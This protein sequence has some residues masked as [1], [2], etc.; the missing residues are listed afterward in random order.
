MLKILKKWRGYSGILYS[1]LFLV[2]LWAAAEAQ[3]I[4]DSGALIKQ[5]EQLQEKIVPK[6]DSLPEKFDY[7]PLREGEGQT[8]LIREIRFSGALE[9]VPES[10]LHN[11]VADAIGKNLDFSGLQMLVN[12]VTDYLKKQG[13]FLAR[14]Y[15]PEQDVTEGVLEIGIL[16]GHLSSD[17]P[18]DI[19]FPD[20]NPRISKKVLSNVV[21]TAL[22]SGEAVNENRINR[23]V[24]LINDFPGVMAKARLKPGTGRDETTMEL[25]VHESSLLETAFTVNNFGSKSTGEEMLMF[26]GAFNDPCGI[27]DQVSLGINRSEGMKLGRAGYSLP[28]LPNGLKLTLNYTG[29]KYDIIDEFNTGGFGGQSSTYTTGLSYPWIRSRIKNVR[30]GVAFSIKDNK[31]WSSAGILHN[32]DIRTGQFSVG[33]DW[34]D[35]AGGGGSSNWQLAL[36]HG[37]LDLN[38][39]EEID[40][41]SNGYHTSGH[42]QKLSFSFSRLQKLPGHFTLFGDL[43]GQLANKNLDSSEKIYPGGPSSIR[44]YSSSEPGGD[45][46]ILGTLEL[47]YDLPQKTPLGNI[48]LQSFLDAGWIHLHDDTG[49]I[50]IN[51]E[52]GRNDYPLGG[53]GVGMQIQRPGLYSFKI[54]WVHVLGDNPGNYIGA[55]EDAHR[56]WMQFDLKI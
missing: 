7:S 47:H 3:E 44:A 15:L 4:P 32:K 55:K 29:M 18:L 17:T 11:L 48:Q 12:R 1:I 6:L 22:K 53:I 33:G 39:F 26:N 38:E 5:Q 13:W 20:K 34:L 9:L 25:T 46:G 43:T 41:S 24:L 21:N 52:S 10:D 42:Y 27:G 35:A 8:V 54:L 16:A 23:A 2:V 30:L 36:T 45:K 28:I 40:M 14:A 56:V 50:D 37:Y 49:N 19:V 51:T 31:D